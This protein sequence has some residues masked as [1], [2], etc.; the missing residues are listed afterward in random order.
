MR[1]AINQRQ[2]QVG[3]S[4]R[5]VLLAGPLAVPVALNRLYAADEAQSRSGS[6][7]WISWRNRDR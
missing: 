3:V 5:S 1:A 4:R 7:K 2:G 6:R